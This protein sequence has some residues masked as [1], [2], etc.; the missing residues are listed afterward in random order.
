MTHYFPAFVEM[1]RQR[2]AYAACGTPAHL[3]TYSAEPECP[4]C[5]AWLAQVNQDDEETAAALAAEFP[6]LNVTVR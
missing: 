4:G 2:V 5:R 6:D 1:V 3:D